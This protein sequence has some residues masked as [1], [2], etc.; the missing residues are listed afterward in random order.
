METTELMVNSNLQQIEHKIFTIRG[1]QVIMDR[2]LD[3][4]S[5]VLEKQE[6]EKWKSQIVISNSIKMGLRKPPRVFTEHG[7]AMLSG[8]LH[9]EQAVKANIMIMRAFVS[10]RRFLQTNAQIFHRLDRVELKQVESEHKIEQLFK[11]IDEKSIEPKQGVFFDGQIFDAYVFATS[12]IKGARER[13]VLIDNYVDET[14]L[15]MLDKRKAGVPATIITM[16]I[17]SRL[18]LDLKKHN[19]QYPSIDVLLFGKI[20][21]R[22]LIIDESV[23]HIGASLKDLGKKW[24]A[25]SL[26]QDTAPEELLN[27][28]TN[29]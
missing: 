23:Y 14:V 15:T 16:T 4:F 18:Q 7:V 26:L 17:D 27:K 2:D 6:V 19:A 12:M 21:D 25:F 13:I 1:M 20:H 24:I 29:R 3:D 22:F 8:L 9:S 5:F 10:M 11:K 28:V